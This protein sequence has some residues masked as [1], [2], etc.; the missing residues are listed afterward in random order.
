MYRLAH[1]ESI[2][3]EG[4]YVVILSEGESEEEYC[5]DGYK[6]GEVIEIAGDATRFPT[7][8]ILISR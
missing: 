2:E 4:E 3:G 6:V 5:A 8:R 1:Y 7:N